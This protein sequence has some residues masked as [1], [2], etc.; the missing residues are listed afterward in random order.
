MAQ[1][2]QDISAQRLFE[3]AEAAL[4]AARLSPYSARG[5][6]PYPPSMIGTTRQPRCLDEFSRWE[7]EQGTRFLIR[8]GLLEYPKAA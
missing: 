3:A 7:V 2:N 6:R 4:V 1:P 5:E 8:L